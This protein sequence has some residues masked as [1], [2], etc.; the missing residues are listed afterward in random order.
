[1]TVPG[2]PDRFGHFDADTFVAAQQEPELVIGACLY[3]G[4]LLSIDEW[5]VFAAEYDRLI[6]RKA[7]VAELKAFYWRYMRAVFP[8][9]RYKFWAPDPVAGLFRLPWSAVQEAFRSFFAL[10]VQA[11]IP[12]ASRSAS[13]MSG[14]SS[15]P[16]TASDLLAEIESLLSSSLPPSPS[17]DLSTTSPVRTAGPATAPVTA[18]SPSASSGS[19]TP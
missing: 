10:Q 9:A 12:S 19:S 4:R 6:A 2:T 14:T 5:L 15:A 17:D 16:S 18:S 1:M 8:R 13:R 7:P 3:R 11:S